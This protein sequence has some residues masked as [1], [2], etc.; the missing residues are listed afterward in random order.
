MCELLSED[1]DNSALSPDQQEKLLP[2]LEV[3]HDVF[4]LENGDRGET[5]VIQVQIATD[6]AP[7]RA[8]PVRCVPF[9]V[10]Q[11]VA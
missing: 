4:S 3:F 6:G 9:A 5:D 1:L 2:L 7:P 10:R 11:E 8:Q